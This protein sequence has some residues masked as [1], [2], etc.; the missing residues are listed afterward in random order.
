MLNRGNPWCS[1]TRCQQKHSNLQRGG[2]AAAPPGGPPQLDGAAQ[3]QERNQ[4]SRPGNQA[5]MNLWERL[6]DVLERMRQGP[7][8][9]D[10][11]K[12]PKYNGQGDMEYFLDQFHEVA[13]A[14]N[15]NAASSLIHLRV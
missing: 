5:D 14:N 9:R 13:E 2:E 6:A 8:P 10:A 12:A 7:A 3:Q 4:P 11:F 15:W 1:G